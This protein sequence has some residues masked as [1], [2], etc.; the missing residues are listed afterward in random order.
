M[1]KK[2]SKS[3]TSEPYRLLLSLSDKIDT[4]RSDIYV[5][6]SNL[7]VYNT[8]KNVKD[9]YKNNKFKISDPAWKNFF[10]LS[11]ES[12]SGADIQNYFK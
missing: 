6:L 11:D 5:A 8:W 9:S 7:N 4:K 12:Y 3:K 10:D 2:R 1:L